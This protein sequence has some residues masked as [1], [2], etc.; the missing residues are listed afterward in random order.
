MW[1]IEAGSYWKASPA[2]AQP[3]DQLKRVPIARHHPPHIWVLRKPTETWAPFAWLTALGGWAGNAE[4]TIYRLIYDSLFF[5]LSSL[6]TLILEAE[7]MMAADVQCN[8]E[9][10]RWKK[11]WWSVYESFYKRWRL[12]NVSLTPFT[13]LSTVFI[14]TDEKAFHFYLNKYRRG[15]KM[16]LDE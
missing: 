2:S 11:I 3:C 12:N 1:S 5:F 8:E 7:H 9:R 6:F 14:R 4:D 15:I 16:R 10:P 13:S